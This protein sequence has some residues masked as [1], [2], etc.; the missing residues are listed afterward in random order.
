MPTDLVLVAQRGAALWL[1]IN[2]PDQHNPLSPGHRRTTPGS[3][4]NSFAEAKDTY[5]T[6]MPRSSPTTFPEGSTKRS[7]PVRAISCPL[8]ITGS[9]VTRPEPELRVDD[10][11][12]FPG[13]HRDH[14]E[15]GG[16]TTRTKR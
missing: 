16:L 4:V 9:D 3:K 12:F 6:P 8:R 5:A 13:R 15:Q 2:R 1:T 14:R 10:E 7:G 11:A